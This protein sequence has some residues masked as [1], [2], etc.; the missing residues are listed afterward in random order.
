MH[1][2]DLDPCKY[3]SGCLDASNW[4]VPLRAIGWLEHPHAFATGPVPED[5]VATLTTLSERTRQEFPHYM[6]RGVHDC[7]LCSATGHQRTG[8][9][10]WSQENV[11]V[12]DLAPAWRTHRIA[13][14]CARSVDEE[15]KWG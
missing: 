11:I 2:N 7:S 8:E 13:R 3:H 10:R 1:F 5:F 9:A 6:F 15:S 14:Q 12:P 4:A